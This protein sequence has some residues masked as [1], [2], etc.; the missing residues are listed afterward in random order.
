MSPGAAKVEKKH[1]AYIWPGGVSSFK[2]EEQIRTTIILHIFLGKTMVFLKFCLWP[3]HNAAKVRMIAW[4]APRAALWEALDPQVSGLENIETDRLRPPNVAKHVVRYQG[5]LWF[6]MVFYGFLWFPMVFLGFCSM[7]CCAILMTM[8]AKMARGF[9]FAAFPLSKQFWFKKGW[10][11]ICGTSYSQLFH[12]H[13][14][15]SRKAEIS[16][17]WFCLGD[18]YKQKWPY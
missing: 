10:P 11:G 9:A 7:A 8:G 16:L 1:I 17:T 4:I 15:P 2:K 6:P 14:P 12:L 5:F 3:C 18:L 13:R